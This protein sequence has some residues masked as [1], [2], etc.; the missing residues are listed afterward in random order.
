LWKHQLL[1]L[2]LREKGARYWRCDDRYEMNQGV[3]LSVFLWTADARSSRRAQR[4]ELCEFH[5]T[6]ELGTE[7]IHFYYHEVREGQWRGAGHTSSPEIQRLGYQTS[8]LR[9]NADQIA[10]RWV[11]ALQCQLLPR[12]SPIDPPRA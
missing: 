6:F 12:R 10:L 2:G 9:E 11:E 3:H 8:P 5:I 4:F 1:E 7:N